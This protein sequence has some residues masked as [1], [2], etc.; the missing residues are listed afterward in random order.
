MKIAF[1]LNI[2]FFAHGM[3]FAKFKIQTRIL[4]FVRNVNT[5][6]FVSFEVLM[7]VI[8]QITIFAVDTNVSE[9]PIYQTTRS[10]LPENWNPI[11]LAF[12]V[13]WYNL[14]GYET[15][16]KSLYD[17]RS[18]GWSVSQSVS[19]SWCH[20]AA[21][22]QDQIFITVRF[23]F[24]HVGRLLWREDGFVVHNCCWASPAQSCLPRSK[25]VVH[26]ICIYSFT[27]HAAFHTASCQD[28]GSLWTPNI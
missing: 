1:V 21:G 3:F 12:S 2:F 16:S 15:K 10:H 13:K 18:V 6:S 17:R 8:I 26:V 5:M 22:A 25:S 24:F 19:M 9:E 20:A 4:L 28:S 7:A 14:L 27:L 23:V 11:F